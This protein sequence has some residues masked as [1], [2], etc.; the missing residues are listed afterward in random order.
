MY[1]VVYYFYVK[2]VLFLPESHLEL[3]EKNQAFCQFQHF[4]N[5]IKTCIFVELD[6]PT[7]KFS[8]VRDLGETKS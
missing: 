3:N 5:A 8:N 4:Y 2:K 7:S 6:T 1:M